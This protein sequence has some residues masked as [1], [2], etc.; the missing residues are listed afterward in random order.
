MLG[1]ELVRDRTTKEPFDR[2]LRVAERVVE[3]AFERGL[4]VYPGS[5]NADGVR[6]DQI[7][8]G[9]PL[10]ISADEIELLAGRLIDAVDAMTADLV[11]DGALVAAG[12]ADPSA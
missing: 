7:L 8:V 2:A 1:V 10:V 12:D 4:I 6:G 3:A 11:A 5:G 9:P